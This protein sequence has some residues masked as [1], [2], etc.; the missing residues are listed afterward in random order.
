MMTVE[1]RDP[2]SLDWQLSVHSPH[3]LPHT[4]TASIQAP[5]DCQLLQAGTTCSVIASGPNPEISTRRCLIHIESSRTGLAGKQ[6][7]AVLRLGY[8]NDGS[9]SWRWR[10]SL[11]PGNKDRETD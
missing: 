6:S 11:L 10:G 8:T 4:T 3:S 5:R 2:D 7:L 1:K 9:S